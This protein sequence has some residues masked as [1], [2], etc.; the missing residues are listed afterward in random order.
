MI[1]DLPQIGEL[2]SDVPDKMTAES[3]TSCLFARLEVSHQTKGGIPLLS[4]FGFIV[5]SND[6]KFGPVSLLYNAIL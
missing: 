2:E 4:V 6:F 1:Y 3:K 5:I